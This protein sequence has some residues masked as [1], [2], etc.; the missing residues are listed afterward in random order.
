LN[1]GAA[2]HAA[3]KCSDIKSGVAFAREVIGS[4][5]ALEKLEQLVGFSR[6]VSLT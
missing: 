4:G 3:G 1:A 5:A 2:F 6:S